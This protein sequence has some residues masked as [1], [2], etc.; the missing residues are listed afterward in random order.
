MFECCHSLSSYMFIID[1]RYVL[2]VILDEQG[3]LAKNTRGVG[4]RVETLLDTV[5]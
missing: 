5:L 3:T 1:M 2:D 4:K